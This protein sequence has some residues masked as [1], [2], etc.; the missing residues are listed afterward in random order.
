MNEKLESVTQLFIQGLY[1]KALDSLVDFEKEEGLNPEDQISYYLLKS[2]IY[3]E[4]GE[5]TD[6]L[7][8]AEQ[9]CNMSEELGSKS[10]LVDSYISKGQVLLLLRD[11]DL[12]LQLI[13]K[14]EEVLKALTI[15]PQSEIAKRNA[16]LKLLKSQ[17]YVY[18]SG[19]M[20]KGLEYAD[21]GL[22]ISEE[23]DN[24]QEIVLALKVS[25]MYY[26][27]IGNFDRALDYLERCLKIQRTYRKRGDWLTLNNLGALNGI[28]G[29]LDLALDYTK[30]SLA[31]A[32]EISNKTFI[33]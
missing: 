31:L 25:S 11:Y 24:K 2:N 23:H 22:K 28:R 32:E 10:L 29:E 17:Y 19:N 5:Y 3:Y 8:F 9:A 12:V 14:G 33:A 7:K 4:L 30:Q 21:K 16:L 1:F 20:D 6:A 26:F 13:S 18:N 15:K 27:S